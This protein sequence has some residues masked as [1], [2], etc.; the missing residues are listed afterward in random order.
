MSDERHDHGATS[1]AT[2]LRLVPPRRPLPDSVPR[3]AHPLVGRGGELDR[4][5]AAVLG[6]RS[7]LVTLT[8][9]GGVGKTRLAIEVAHRLWPELPGTIVFVAARA[10]TSADELPSLIAAAAELA[11]AN[12]A[13][14]LDV[15]EVGLAE[16][17]T[18]LMLDNGEQIERLDELVAR[19]LSACPDLT[20]LLTSRR[21]LGIDQE[22]VVAVEPLAADDAVSLL[23]ATARRVDPTFELTHANADAVTELCRRLDRLPLALELA[24]ARLRLITADEMVALLARRFDVLR[25]SRRDTSEGGSLWAT[26]DWSYQLLEEADQS[27]FRSLAVFPDTFTM[28]AAASVAGCDEVAM[29]DSLGALVD[30]HLVQPAGKGSG[31]ARFVMLETLREYAAGQLDAAGER[32]RAAEAHADW[33]AGLVAELEP[34]WTTPR[35]AEAAAR[36][37][38]E[39]AN[40]RAALDWSLTTGHAERVL[41]IMS[42][43]WR[44]WR[45]RGRAREG[46]ALIEAALD[47][48]G[49][50]E[51]DRALV[52]RGLRTAGELADD[53][54]AMER[55]VELFGGA[56][57]IYEELGDEAALA[58]ARNGQAA[59]LRELG[60]LDRA[61]QLHESA[62]TVFRRL[63]MHR[64]LAMCLNGLGGIASRRGDHAA[65]ATHFEQAYAIV[66]RLGDKRSQGVIAGNVGIAKFQAGDLDGAVAAHTLAVTIADEMGDPLAGLIPLLNRAE[67]QI[68]AGRFDEAEVGLARAESVAEQI[69]YAYAAVIVPHHRGLIAEAQGRLGAAARWHA[70]SLRQALVASRSLDAV[71]CV[72]RLAMLAAQLGADDLARRAFGVAELARRVT[73]SAPT[74]GIDRWIAALGAVPPEPPP[75]DWTDVLDAIAPEL[76]RFAIAHADAVGD[77]P[78]DPAQ[79]A[80]PDPVDAVLRR[81]GLSARE[82]EVARLVVAGRTDR[83]IAAELFIGVRTVASHV[84]AVLRKL[85]VSSRREVGPRL[86]EL[87]TDP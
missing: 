42:R 64:Q 7:G 21:A 62:V 33:C 19:L 8:G 41:E 36:F 44:Y 81:A 32:S 31:V 6:G 77:P 18:L 83:E 70:D 84:S 57:A 63:G 3:P 55:S 60:E 82:V 66:E 49:A 16:R 59:V 85:G 24:A 37:E 4:I 74:W 53:A 86:V 73:G 40:L 50:G 65:A 67:V 87:G 39:I 76:E 47:L 15:V 30:H 51:I 48:P 80:G 72:E 43:G 68:E 5:R 71:E 35:E 78:G 23:A 26:I 52:G 38:Y 2:T 54:S 69:G 12:D 28:G 10:V 13:D 11:V 20:V 27:R 58:E 17:P 75:V 25:A 46:L 22:R 1:A 56:I 61:A 9:T 45:T 29:L 14:A 79:A 34:A